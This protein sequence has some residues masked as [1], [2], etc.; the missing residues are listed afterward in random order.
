MSLNNEPERIDSDSLSES[1]NLAS[2]PLSDYDCDSEW[3][4]SGDD[5]DSDDDGMRG[6]HK[7][8]AMNLKF[9]LDA[10]KAGE[11]CVATCI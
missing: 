8:G 7:P 2:A 6:S 5:V 1:E 3:E 10:A 11:C 4:A 9:Q